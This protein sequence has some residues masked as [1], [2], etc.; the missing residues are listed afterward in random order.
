M[1]Q[2]MGGRMSDRTEWLNNNI[3]NELL[4]IG[5]EG[6][7]KQASRSLERPGALPFYRWVREMARVPNDKWTGCDKA[8]SKAKV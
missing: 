4:Y 5:V 2:S 6:C 8:Y 7:C 3:N 1:L